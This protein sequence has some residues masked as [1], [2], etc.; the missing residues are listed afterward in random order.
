ME[1]QN[2]FSSWPRAVVLLIF[3]LLLPYFFSVFSAWETIVG[4]AIFGNDFAGEVLEK[5]EG[6]TPP[7]ITT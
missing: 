2:F 1:K 7:P 3:L 4:E 6:K 5:A